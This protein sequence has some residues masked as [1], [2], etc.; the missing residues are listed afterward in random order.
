MLGFWDEA[1]SIRA[2][3]LFEARDLEGRTSRRGQ[4]P[5]LRALSGGQFTDYEVIWLRPDGERRRIV[6]T[7]TSVKDPDGKVALAI[8]VLRDVTDQRCSEL[9]RSLRRPSR[10]MSAESVGLPPAV[11]GDAPIGHSSSRPCSLTSACGAPRRSPRPSPAFGEWRRN[12]SVPRAGLA[13]A[14]HF[15]SG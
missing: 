2:L 1:P 8:V 7:G 15:R 11:V 6:S 4:R 14:L 12:E 9:Q 3:H 10:S 5:L 13:R